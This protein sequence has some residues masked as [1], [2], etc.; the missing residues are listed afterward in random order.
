M[1]GV[2]MGGREYIGHEMIS[3]VFPHTHQAG[4]GGGG[5]VVAGNGNGLCIILP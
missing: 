3:F 5:F 4:T 1:Q 2:G